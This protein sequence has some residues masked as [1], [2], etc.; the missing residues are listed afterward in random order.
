MKNYRPNVWLT[1]AANVNS[2]LS[3]AEVIVPQRNNSIKLLVDIFRYHF[4]KKEGLRLLDIGC[5]DGIVS[6]WIRR[7]YPNNNFFLLDGS[8]EML[9]KAKERL[10]GENIT[11]M[12][13]TFEGYVNPAFE[14]DKFDF[15]Y[16]ANAIHHLDLP[17]KSKLYRK[18]FNELKPG[19]LF[20]NIDLV[21]PSSG[22]SEIWQFNMWRDWM[23]ETLYDKGFQKDIG[24]YDEVPCHYKN[25]EQNKPDSLFD[26]LKLLKRIGFQDVDCFYKFGVVAIFGGTKQGS[27]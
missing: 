14:S 26:Q 27:C 25:N 18:V 19:G 3:S 6:D 21:L 11:L 9:E 8:S 16:S 23:N 2:Y 12:H 4:K 1:D 17:E 5:G 10:K 20:L 24:K 7:R 13:Q 15:M 22:I